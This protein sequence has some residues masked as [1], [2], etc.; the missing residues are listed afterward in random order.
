MIWSEW[1]W[2]DE[3]MN[4]IIVYGVTW[5]LVVIESP[6]RVALSCSNAFTG[7]KK[8]KTITIIARS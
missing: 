3:G 7:E 6:V 2:F 8:R 4:N 5:V 1:T